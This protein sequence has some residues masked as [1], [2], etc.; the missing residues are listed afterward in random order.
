MYYPAIFLYNVDMEET[1]MYRSIV[2]AV[3]DHAR[4]LPGKLCVA[5][6]KRSYTYDQFLNFVYALCEILKEYENRLIVIRCNQ[7][8]VYLAVKLACELLNIV[9]VPVEKDASAVRISEIIN[10]TEA[11]LYISDKPIEGIGCPVIDYPVYDDEKHEFELVFPE[12]DTT[13][14]ILFTT[15]TTG[16]SKGVVISN[17][18]NIALAENIIYGSMMKKNNVELLP[19]PISHSHGLRSCY[20]N[21]LNGSS[22]VLTNGVMMVKQVFDLIDKY[23]VTSIDFSPSAVKVFM[24]LAKEQFFALK[25]RL[26]YIEIG[27]AVLDEETKRTLIEQF[28]NTR[29]LNFY[30]STESGRSCVLDFQKVNLNKCVGKPTKNAHFIV[31]DEQRNE[32]HSSFEN[33]GLLACAGKMNMKGYFKQPELSA[34]TMKDGYIYT[35]DLSYIDEE[36]YVYVLGRK[37][38]VIN[39]GGIKIAPDEIEEQVLKFQGIE[40]C[41]CVPKNDEVYGQVPYLFIVVKD[42]ENFDMKELGVF[43]RKHID[44]NKLPK[45]IQMI[46]KIPRTF[47][48]KMQRGPL[49]ELC[50]SQN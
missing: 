17:G 49:I 43:M 20:A 9:F 41:A 10:E 34:E 32:I 31:T 19:L 40:D 1:R 16:K 21:L 38:S 47:N 39:Y 7:D 48:G 35:N 26:D 23:N 22:I 46:D 8:A 28:P 2:E 27:T 24:K 13:A 30:G 25:D 14:E 44:N 18:N 5:D 42:E 6:Q 29:L 45:Q 4:Y 33:M 50:N 36:G 11:S 12:S 37:D 3:I 15:G